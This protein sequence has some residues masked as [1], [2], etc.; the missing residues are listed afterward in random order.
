MPTIFGT[1]STGVKMQVIPKDV[2]DAIEMKLEADSQPTTYK[3][4]AMDFPYVLEG[5]EYELWNQMCA[6]WKALQA[7]K[8]TE[9]NEKA[10]RYAVTVT[11]LEKVMAYFNTFVWEECDPNLLP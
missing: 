1:F 6:L 2:L 3:H 7:A 11:E 10:R 8:P 4:D 5:M 9:R